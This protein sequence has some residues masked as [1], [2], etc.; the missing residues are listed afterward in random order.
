MYGGNTRISCSER[1]CAVPC[2]ACDDC[3]QVHTW[4]GPVPSLD[5]DTDT[6]R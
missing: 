6:H 1:H 3:P 5:A 2:C 4:H